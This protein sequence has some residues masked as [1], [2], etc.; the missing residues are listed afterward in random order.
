MAAIKEAIGYSKLT[1]FYD[2]KETIGKG[3]SGIVKTA[4]H[5]K[6][7][8][9]V[10]VKVMAKKEMTQQ[11]IELQRREVEILKMCQHPN[12][13]RLLDLFENEDYIYIVMEN[14]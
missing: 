9:R 6:T 4:Y 14:M 13:I 11:D 3:K 8:K 7:G 12:I 2:V 10:A 1:D 5:K